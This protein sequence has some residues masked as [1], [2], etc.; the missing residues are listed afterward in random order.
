MKLVKIK[1]R[2]PEPERKVKVWAIS[3]RRGNRA[4]LSNCYIRVNDGIEL[5]WRYVEDVNGLDLHCGYFDH[6]NC[7][8]GEWIPEEWEDN[9][10]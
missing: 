10:E 4:S 2:L 8:N 1:D 7:N 5:E 6:Y 3:K 9:N